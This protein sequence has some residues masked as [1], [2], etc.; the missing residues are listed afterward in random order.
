MWCESP[1]VG[2][3]LTEE[4]LAEDQG[5]ETEGWGLDHQGCQPPDAVLGVFIVLLLFILIKLGDAQAGWDQTISWVKSM[6]GDRGMESV[7][8]TVLWIFIDLSQFN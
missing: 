3:S 7:S 5:G 4:D 2:E 1:A 6:Q 8:S